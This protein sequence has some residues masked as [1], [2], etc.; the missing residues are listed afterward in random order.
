MRGQIIVENKTGKP[1]LYV[2]EA[3]IYFNA[4]TFADG[5]RET[6]VMAF[7]ADGYYRV[8]GGLI[9]MQQ[10]LQNNYRFGAEVE[11][12]DRIVVFAIATE[13]EMQVFVNGAAGVLNTAVKSQDPEDG[14]R[15]FQI[16]PI[17][18]DYTALASVELEIGLEIHRI[19]RE[20]GGQ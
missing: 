7:R 5:R 2:T 1:W 3:H 14:F 13:R 9:P 18:D 4:T 15:E 17:S 10:W 12:P 6:I 16:L 20:A 8:P 19:I 11:V